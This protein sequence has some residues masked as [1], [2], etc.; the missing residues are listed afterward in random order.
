MC[1]CV[2]CLCVYVCVEPFRAR[3]ADLIPNKQET[4]L[5][6]QVTYMCSTGSGEPSRLCTDSIYLVS[7]IQQAGGSIIVQHAPIFYGPNFC[8]WF[9][10]VLNDFFF[11]APP[12]SLLP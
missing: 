8:V 5:G 10:G 3:A 9:A 1:V 2:V 7:Y 11:T 4:L 6:I 12:S